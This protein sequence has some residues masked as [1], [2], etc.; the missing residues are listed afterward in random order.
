MDEND[1]ELM[2]L[3]PFLESLLDKVG[4]CDA[5]YGILNVL[6]II[7]IYGKLHVNLMMHVWSS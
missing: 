2:K 7:T 4:T 1:R 6:I 3:L 5:L